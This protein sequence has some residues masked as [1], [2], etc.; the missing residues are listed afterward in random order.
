MS[1]SQFQEYRYPDPGDRL[2]ATF[3]LRSELEEAEW[4]RQESQ[5]LDLLSEPWRRLDP[6][7]RLLDFGSGLGRLTLRFAGGFDRV[8]SVEPDADRAAGQREAVAASPHGSRVE[9]RSEVS[10]EADR[11]YDA[12]LCSHVIQHVTADAALAVLNELARLLQPGGH[13]LL[14][15]TLAPDGEDRYAIKE[16]GR[17]GF[18][19]RDVG[20][21]EFDAACRVNRTGLLPVHFYGYPGLV[22]D[23]ERRGLD[24]VGGYGFHG[25]HG[26]VG[27]LAIPP[28]RTSEFDACRDLAVLAVRR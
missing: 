17:G 21:E 12:V 6:P 7:A 19:E 22:A 1:A 15:T 28:E 24:V 10:S 13:L 16:N 8:V 14:T 4:A 11:T 9:I 27:P 3:I 2:T 23:L 18:S 5:V 25:V 26:V 20:P